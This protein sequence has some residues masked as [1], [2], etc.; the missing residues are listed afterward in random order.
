MLTFVSLSTPSVMLSPFQVEQLAH[1]ELVGKAVAIQQHYDTISMNQKAK[2]AGVTKHMPPPQVRASSHPCMLQVCSV[3]RVPV[4]R[5]AC[6]TAP[7][8]LKNSHYNFCYS[9]SSVPAR[10]I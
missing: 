6:Q 3:T 1:P 7:S 8:H 4:Q 5:P 9:T 2:E 10:R